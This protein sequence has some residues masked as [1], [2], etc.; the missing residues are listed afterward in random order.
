MASM[1]AIQIRKLRSNF[2]TLWQYATM[3]PCGTNQR[4]AMNRLHAD[5]QDLLGKLESVG[6]KGKTLCEVFAEEER[7]RNHDNR[8][9][10][11]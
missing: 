10:G 4:A 11:S 5:T 7:Q 6:L 1:F 3:Q 2:E 8:R 9:N